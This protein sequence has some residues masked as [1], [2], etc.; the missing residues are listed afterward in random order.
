MKKNTKVLRD[1]KDGEAQTVWDGEKESEDLP[2]D[3]WEVSHSI[4]DP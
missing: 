3:V 4:R 1:G 2:F